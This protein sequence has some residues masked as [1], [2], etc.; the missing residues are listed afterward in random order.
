[1]LLM[2]DYNGMI[3]TVDSALESLR[4]LEPF[5]ILFCEEPL[6]PS[7]IAGYAL[8]LRRRSPIR[9]AAG[10]GALR[11]RRFQAG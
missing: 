7:D 9:V 4:K 2:V 11:R 1:M 3:S 5:N 8:E 10:E 6:P